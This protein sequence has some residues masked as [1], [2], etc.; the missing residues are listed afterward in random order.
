MRKLSLHWR[1]IIGMLLGVV[2]SIFASI[3]GWSSFTINWISPFGDI[4]INLLKLI[5]VPLVVFSV[6]KGVSSISNIS[7]LGR[8]GFKTLSAYLL[9]TILS[10]SIGLL[11]V[12]LIKPKK[13]ILTNL[14]LKLDYKNLTQKLP[15]NVRVAY[16]GLK[17]IL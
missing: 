2:W 8:M 5:A 14:S 1:I 4:F 11:I 13:T 12:N 7:L 17:L 6:I 10:V 15:F 3:F 9:T 16:D